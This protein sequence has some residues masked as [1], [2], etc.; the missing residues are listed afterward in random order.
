MKPKIGALCVLAS[1]LIGAP[2][3]AADADDKKWIAQCMKDN[4]DEGAKEDVVRKYCICMND[5]MDENETRSI[6]QWE[7]ANPKAMKDCDKQA[8]WR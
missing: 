7:K 3:V 1:L 4:K 8:G 6:S 2:A 5:K